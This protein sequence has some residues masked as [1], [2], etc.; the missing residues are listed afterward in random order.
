ME[1]LRLSVPPALGRRTI[2]E[3]AER[4]G[5]RPTKA[6]G[7]NFL[8]DPNLARAIAT[9]VG[10]APGVRVLEIGAGL[11]S[12][13]TALAATGADVLAVE[14]DRALV[15]ALTEV[16]G[17]LGNVRIEVADAMRLDW[18]S[19]LGDGEW[20]MASNLPYNVAV[21]LLLDLLLVAPGIAI[22]VVM[23]QREVADRL[24][25]SAGAEAYGAVSV[26]VAYHADA[27]M[28]R[29]VPPS[30]FWPEPKV[31]SALVRLLPHP[32]RVSTPRGALFRVIDEGFA[33]RRK[34]MGNAL[35]RLGLD[36]TRAT[37]VLERCAIASDARAETLDLAAF[38]RIT[39]ALIAD[40][41]ELPGAA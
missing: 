36:A 1:R 10:A 35:K 28:L 18:S 5:I 32:P 2:R 39:D 34:T 15:P 20:A 8:I 25:A 24:A 7:Q 33:Q 14:F 21:P 16:V 23:V 29:A 37:S 19:V 31:G 22:Y 12:L 17:S 27:S 9:A 30:V 38:A 4:H 11:G 13:T 41:L 6:L 40:G 26:K 3:L